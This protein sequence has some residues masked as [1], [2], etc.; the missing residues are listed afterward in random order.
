MQITNASQLTGVFPALFTPLKN[1]DPKNLRNSIDYE[2]MGKMIDDV[3][4]NG[5]SG[6]LPAVTTGQ[7]ATVS[8]QQ[9]L[10]VIK[11]TL[12]YVDG[13]VPVIAGAGSNCTRES[14]EMIENVQK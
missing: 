13:R 6:V 9:H 10:D 8:P 2:K 4:A 1:D 7:S 3:I 5:A 12:D 11:F 14:I